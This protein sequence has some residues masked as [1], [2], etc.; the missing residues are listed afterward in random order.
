[1]AKKKPEF[2]ASVYRT[3]VEDY[4]GAG[5]CNC[6]LRKTSTTTRFKKRGLQ[7]AER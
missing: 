1:M 2:E 3:S 7:T 4:L 6:R 5:R